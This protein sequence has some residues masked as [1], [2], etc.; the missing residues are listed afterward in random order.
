MATSM[1]AA[2]RTAPIMM[3]AGVPMFGSWGT[4]GTPVIRG[5]WGCARWR[6]LGHCATTKLNVM[7]H[8][9]KSGER[10]CA[11]TIVVERSDPGSV[12]SPDTSP[13]G[14]KE[15]YKLRQ[16]PVEAPGS[17]DCPGVLFCG[18]QHQNS[19]VCVSYRT[20]SVSSVTVSLLARIASR[21][22]RG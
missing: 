8:Y 12:P 4:D 19:R 1:A 6:P 15:T 14:S 13:P 11:Y 21:E 16:Q 10:W 2:I 22:R 20:G 7:R 18:R 3:D 5:N 17:L 9:A